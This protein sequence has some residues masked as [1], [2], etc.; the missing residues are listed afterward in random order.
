MPKSSIPRGSGR[1]RG[2]GTYGRAN[3]GAGMSENHGDGALLT[4]EPLVET[5]Q[6]ALEGEGWRL[7]G[8][9]KT[10]SY[11]YQG[12]WAGESTRSAYLFFHREGLTHAC[13][14][15]A[16]LDETSD[17]LAGN[18]ALVVDGPPLDEIGDVTS[19]I[20]ILRARAIAALPA[21]YRETVAVRL[22]L[23]GLRSAR[24]RVESEL[25]FK[26]I[27]P[28][29][30]IAA[31]GSAVH[32]LCAAVTRAFESLLADAELAAWLR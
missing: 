8:T 26:V 25:R 3:R 19:F 18:L 29:T 15:D 1:V 9:Q 17:G 10:T 12:K 27:I 21:E 11:E 5:V 23:P 20:A 32:E 2:P 4:L 14:V 28:E 22:L 24:S 7:S 31:G 30:V 16:F 13:S 6:S